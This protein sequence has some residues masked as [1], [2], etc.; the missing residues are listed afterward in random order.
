LHGNSSALVIATPRRNEKRAWDEGTCR[1]S[2]GKRQ[3]VEQ[4]VSHLKDLFSLERHRAR[5]L[6]GLL[7][8]I[9][10][11]IVAYTIG[12]YIN[13]FCLSRPMRRLADLLI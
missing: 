6:S 12:L 2:A 1:W 5:T 3:V 10:A 7:A 9:A 13:L 4:T 8:R 11:R